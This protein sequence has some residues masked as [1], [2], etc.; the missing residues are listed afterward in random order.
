MTCFFCVTE[1]GPGGTRLGVHEAIG[2]CMDCGAGLCQHHAHR[3]A[4]N[5]PL[6]CAA[7]AEAH[8]STVEA[9]MAASR[10]PS[11]GR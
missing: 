3:S 9:V 2:I 6:R 5:E 1:G 11:A 10:A 7:H 4:P 8:H